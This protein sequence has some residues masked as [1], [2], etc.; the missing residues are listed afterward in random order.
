MQAIFCL[1][2]GK[3]RTSETAVAAAVMFE[4]CHV[5]DWVVMSHFLGA[6]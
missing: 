5:I 2:S 6:Q 1:L 3:T 4:L